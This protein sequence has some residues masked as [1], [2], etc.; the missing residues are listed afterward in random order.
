[1][2]YNENIVEDHKG[3]AI[4][5]IFH[6]SVNA[7][8]RVYRQHHHTAFEISVI[9]SGEGT[10][11]VNSRTYDFK[12]GD[13]FVFSSDE[14]HCIT[15]IYDCEKLDLINIHFEPM[16]IWSDETGLND[17]NLLKIFLDRN[18][19]FQNRIDRENPAS[20]IIKNLIFEMDKEFAVK[21]EEY[22]LAVKVKLITIL[23][24]LIRD[25]D[26]I[27]NDNTYVLKSDNLVCLK[28][29]I[30]YINDNLSSDITLDDLAEAASMSRSRF[31]TVFK[32]YNGI[33]PW[34]YITIK[35]IE[36][37]VALLAEKNMTKLEIACKCGFNN[38]SNFYRA[39]KKVTGK[40][41]SDYC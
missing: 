1:M 5:K 12:K 8:K 27:N 11:S 13:V 18:D 31:C 32:K 2:V 33:S 30:D 15:D 17:T 7:G 36:M 22:L 25:F 6:S 35:R 21:Q 10:Y 28:K 38:T 34:D 4:F 19:N 26:Y 23:I 24:S 40:I 14:V 29:S 20:E 39:F 37:S 41:P 9:A 16:Y 3:H